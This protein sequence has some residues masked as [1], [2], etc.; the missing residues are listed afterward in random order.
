MHHIIIT[1]LQ[2]VYTWLILQLCGRSGP[3]GTH[4]NSVLYDRKTSRPGVGVML[5]HVRPDH[6]GP[7][8]GHPL[9]RRL[10]ASDCARLRGGEAQCPITHMPSSAAD[11]PIPPQCLRCVKGV[12]SYT[13]LIH[14]L[15]I[16]RVP[17]VWRF[18]TQ[19]P[20]EPAGL[21]SEGA[22]VI[23]LH[24]EGSLTIP[25]SG[26]QRVYLWEC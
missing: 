12:H 20:P 18:C 11:H 13:L 9:R 6:G 15:G 1:V 25:T 21:F 7:A 10:P 23:Q 17:S 3:T 26:V 16:I 22:E 2:C 8:E 5:W 24:V 4:G 14:V 19:S